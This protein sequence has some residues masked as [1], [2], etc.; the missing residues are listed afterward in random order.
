[1]RRMIPLLAAVLAWGCEAAPAPTR[2]GPRGALARLGPCVDRGDAAC[3]FGELDRDSRWSVETIHR[4][5]V[6]G[7]ALV[8]RSYPEQSRAVALGIWTAA[9]RA[10]TPAGCF[11]A[12]AADRGWLA[13]VAGGFGAAVEVRDTGPGEAEVTT[14]RG[15]RFPFASRD[16][17]WGLALW[18]AE[19]Q[20]DKLRILD[21]LEQIRRNAG[22]FDEQRAAR[23]DGLR[24]EE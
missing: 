10:G 16:G 3:L 1:M 13:R 12:L 22:E 24:H 15:Q 4:A 2:E 5:L 21:N 6:E 7:R 18:T 19:L 14:T 17:E 23:G 8:E 11:A 9:A 20:R